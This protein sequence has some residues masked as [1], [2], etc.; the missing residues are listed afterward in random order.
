MTERAMSLWPNKGDHDPRPPV[1]APYERLA[2]VE[3]AR[4]AVPASAPAALRLG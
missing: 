4:P 2:P 3:P 1:G